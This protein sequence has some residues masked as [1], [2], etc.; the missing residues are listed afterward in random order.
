M[1]RDLVTFFQQYTRG[2]PDLTVFRLGIAQGRRVVEPGQHCVQLSLA[3]RFALETVEQ[4]STHVFELL[5]R[6]L[7]LGAVI[8]MGR[9]AGSLCQRQRARRIFC[10]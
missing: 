1:L 6:A 2:T 4:R 8:Q 3:H 10:Q 7:T 5:N 9:H